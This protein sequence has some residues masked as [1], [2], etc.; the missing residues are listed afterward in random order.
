[1]KPKLQ[2]LYNP[3]GITVPIVGEIWEGM[4]AEVA[5]AMEEPLAKTTTTLGKPATIV[6]DIHSPGGSVFDGYRI[7]N[8]IEAKKKLGHR[9]EVRINALAASM[10]SVVAM[11][12]DTITIPENGWI[13]VHE[14]W[15]LSVG[16]A[17]DLRREADLLDRLADQIVGIY[18]KR[19]GIEEAEIR[20]LMADETWIAGADA[21]TLGWADEATPAVAAAAM[22]V[23]PE[24]AAKWRHCPPLGMD[25]APPPPAPIED[26]RTLEFDF[27][28]AVEP[29][30]EAPVEEP[31]E[32]AADD[33]ALVDPPVVPEDEAAEAG[34]AGSAA[35]PDP[36]AGPKGWLQRVRDALGGNAELKLRLDA[37]ELRAAELE[38]EVA[39]LRERA[40]DRDRI[41]L[42][43]ESVTA[44]VESESKLA[45]D[46]AR[47]AADFALALGASSG[48][49]SDDPLP[50]P[51]GNTPAGVRDQW[52]AMP[53]G[54]GRARFY[55][56]HRSE[57]EAEERA[58]R[59]D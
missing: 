58:S 22:A 49:G 39:A 15:G 1:M 18:A 34:P 16:N 35:V 59:P 50:R 3:E 53:A 33:E 19:T 17:D 55:S 31:E 52:L 8:L 5:D 54:E 20:R 25:D 12:G 26:D 44:L 9:C 48:P 6:L 7:Y 27:P 45:K 51:C 23:E 47:K 40:A 24:M 32:P 41:A 13:M 46:A 56:E 4:A 2:V 29:E 10:A 30:E 21:V 14:P 11:V 37:A 57:I 36:G 42:E 38:T 28:P 43:L